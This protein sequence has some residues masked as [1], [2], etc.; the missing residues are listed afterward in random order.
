M[1]FETYHI[2]PME[3]DS[4]FIRAIDSTD[5]VE[6]GGLPGSIGSDESNDLSL[7]HIERDVREDGEPTEMFCD[8]LDLK[9]SGGFDSLMPPLCLY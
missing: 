6:E 4:S 2:F 9:N 1:R 3:A 5:N 7:T 8:V